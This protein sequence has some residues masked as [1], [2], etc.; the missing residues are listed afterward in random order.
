MLTLSVWIDTLTPKRLSVDA[1]KLLMTSAAEEASR[2]GDRRLGT[3]HPL[4]GILH[5]EDS[6]AAKAP[7]VSLADARAAVDRLDAAALAAVGIRAEPM[8]AAPPTPFGRRFPPSRGGG[9][10]N[11][12]ASVTTLR[13]VAG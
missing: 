4:L 1:R 6:P 5:A 13:R 9:R 11:R 10:V 7:G 3:D 2:R 12:R 8:G